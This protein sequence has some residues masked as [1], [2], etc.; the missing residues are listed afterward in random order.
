[1]LSNPNFY[2]YLSLILFLLT[3]N[4]YSK[5]KNKA[6]LT[7]IASIISTA[8]YYTYSGKQLLTN[9]QAKEMIK[10][11]KINYIIDIRT[12]MEWNLGHHPKAVHMPVSELKNKIKKYSKNKSYLLYCN[13][14]QRARKGAEIMEKLGFKKVYYVPNTYKQIM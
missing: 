14:G 10:N 11:N 6:L 5:N 8:F 3:I 4:F 12:N 13:S 1:M 7:F 2:L 9:K